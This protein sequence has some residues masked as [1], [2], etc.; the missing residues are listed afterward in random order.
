M[1][2][3]NFLKPFIAPAVAP[4]IGALLAFIANKFGIRYTPDQEAQIR[5]GVVAGILFIV[6][7]AASLSGIVKVG[8]NKKLN[9]AN[10]ATS[11]LVNKG[12]AEGKAL[13]G[14]T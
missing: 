3:L 4:F 13:G 12:N 7:T 14:A 11:E 10:A 1:D 6:A 8:M 9:R 5:E 2:K